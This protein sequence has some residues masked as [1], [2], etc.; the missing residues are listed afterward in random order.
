MVMT[1]FWRNDDVICR[2]NYT[3]L[4]S[5]WF[6]TIL[7]H[8]ISITINSFRVMGRGTF[9]PP[10]LTQAPK[11]SP[12]R[13]GLKRAWFSQWNFMCAERLFWICSGISVMDCHFPDF[14][15]EAKQNSGQYCNQNVLFSGLKLCIMSLCYFYGIKTSSNSGIYLMS[16]L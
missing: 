1:S 13:I 12:G 4:I 2:L 5:L 7:P 16:Y 10:P 15:I 14:R 11:K 8:F 3:R 9:R 6:S